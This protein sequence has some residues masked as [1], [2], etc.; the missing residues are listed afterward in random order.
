MLQIKF[1]ES[2][3]CCTVR[4]SSAL[5]RIHTNLYPKHYVVQVI[6]NLMFHPSLNFLPH[7]WHQPK[8]SWLWIKSTVFSWGENIF[9]HSFGA[10]L[11]TKISSTLAGYKTRHESLADLCSYSDLERLRNVVNIFDLKISVGGEMACVF[12]YIMNKWVWANT[13]LKG[14]LH[15]E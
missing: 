13:E 7:V 5:V 2:Y 8:G 6:R 9:K 14:S 12:L 1:Y 11:P 15:K 10:P 4:H 3:A